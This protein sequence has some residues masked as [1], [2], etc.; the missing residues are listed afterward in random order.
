ME[1]SNWLATFNGESAWAVEPM[2]KTEPAAS[3]A[4]VLRRFLRVFIKSGKEGED[5][6][7]AEINFRK[8]NTKT[9]LPF[10]LI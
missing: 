5:L 10:C 3:P 6:N 8:L 1:P 2:W 7:K 9:T 4:L